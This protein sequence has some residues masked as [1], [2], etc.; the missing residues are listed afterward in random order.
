MLLPS[1]KIIEG[2]GLR[3]GGIA[4]NMGALAPL[5]ALLPKIIV[6]I[7]AQIHVCITTIYEDRRLQ[8]I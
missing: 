7:G 1:P 3:L 6:G 2:A 5:T 8:M 4:I